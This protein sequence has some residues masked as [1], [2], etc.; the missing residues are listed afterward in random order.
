MDSTALA[1][2]LAL[3]ASTVH[4]ALTP[5]ATP[6]P[7]CQ[8]VQSTMLMGNPLALAQELASAPPQALVTMVTM[9]M[10]TALAWDLVWA[11]ASVLVDTVRA[12]QAPTQVQAL[13]AGWAVGLAPTQALVQVPTTCICCSKSSSHQ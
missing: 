11:L 6:R 7:P 4:K 8:E 2:V 10:A 3:A 13:A 9:A 12:A 1:W 5:L